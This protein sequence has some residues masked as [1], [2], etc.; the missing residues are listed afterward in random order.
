MNPDAF[1]RYVFDASEAAFDDASVVDIEDARRLLRDSPDLA[2]RLLHDES[3]ESRLKQLDYSMRDF[4]R[5]SCEAV[6]IIVGRHE[7]RLEPCVAVAARLLCASMMAWGGGSGKWLILPKLEAQERRRAVAAIQRGEFASVQS[8]GAPQL[9][10]LVVDH[11]VSGFRQVSPW[12]HDLTR[13]AVVAALGSMPTRGGALPVAEFRIMALHSWCCHYGEDESSE[14]DD[15]ARAAGATS[16][17]FQSLRD[18]I[19]ASEPVDD[20]WAAP[21]AIDWERLEQYRH[22]DRSRRW[23]G[24]EINQS[25]IALCAALRAELAN[26]SDPWVR[27]AHAGAIEGPSSR[28]LF[29]LLVELGEGRTSR[30]RLMAELWRQGLLEGDAA[31]GALD[32]EV[33]P[34]RV[35][36]TSIA[37]R[38][39][40]VDQIRSGGFGELPPALAAWFEDAR[41]AYFG[42]APSLARHPLEGPA[43]QELRINPPRAL[44]ALRDRIIAAERE[45]LL[46]KAKAINR[47]WMFLLVEHAERNP[48]DPFRW[49]D[50]RGILVASDRD[51]LLKLV[52]RKASAAPGPPWFGIE[53]DLDTEFRLREA[54][55]A[56]KFLDGPAF[57]N[58][59][60]KHITAILASSGMRGGAE[61]EL[62]HLCKRCGRYCLGRLSNAQPRFRT[63]EA[64]RRMDAHAML[65]SEAGSEVVMPVSDVPASIRSP[66]AM[67]ALG[68]AAGVLVVL[69]T[70][71][72]AGGTRPEF[73]AGMGVVAAPGAGGSSPTK[74]PH[75]KLTK[76]LRLK[77]ATPGEVD[78]DLPTLVALL[79][80]AAV[81][82]RE[83]VNVEGAAS[84]LERAQKLAPRGMA[85]SLPTVSADKAHWTG[86][87]VDGIEPGRRKVKLVSERASSAGATK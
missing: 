48:A 56:L 32:S 71:L 19:D 86:A 2:F 43:L 65:E 21:A 78:L 76:E 6:D 66:L 84:V 4:V 18:R 49:D 38:K 14:R 13:R 58:E 51:T 64:F 42:S 17:L 39:L 11:R 46:R 7:A 29:G 5:E 74:E 52:E 59:V 24:L 72:A 73:F 50:G 85:V 8:L 31:I 54:A 47:D 62:E 45:V 25:A 81:D 20:L 15:L 70:L 60:K 26:L 22:Y 12:L 83:T 57:R 80:A 44:Q 63:L 87:G 34:D 75:L 79:G 1:I 35:D 41:T 3:A 40:F 23:L 61:R 55:F 9:L 68:T 69:A 16:P 53:S 30:G 33:P 77:L 36:V 37:F 67:A 10:R 28:R 82:S 27:W